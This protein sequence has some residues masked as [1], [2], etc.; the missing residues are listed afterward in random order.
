MIILE[1]ALTLTLFKPSQK[2]LEL[3]SFANKK[4]KGQWLRS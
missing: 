3:D 1:S 4:I 2:I